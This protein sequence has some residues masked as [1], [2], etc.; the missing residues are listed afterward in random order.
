M[1]THPELNGLRTWIEVDKTALAHNY[2][3]LRGILPT[4]T[5]FMA[6]VK[7]N[8]YGHSLV[9]FSQEVEKLGADWIAV[10]SIVE[11]ETLREQGIKAPILVLGFTLPSKIESAADLGVSLSISSFEMLEEVAEFAKKNPAKKL[12]L[13]IKVDTGM[14]RQGFEEEQISEV[15]SHLKKLPPNVLVEGLFTHFASAKNP[16][17]PNHT[18]GQISK[19]ELWRA[20]FADAGLKPLCHAGASS[21]SILYP[22]SH[23]DMVRFG[24]TMYGLWP[25]AQVR[26]YAEDKLDLQPIL[27]WKTVIAEVK[28]VKKGESVGYDSTEILKRDSLLAV[29]PIGYWH[30]L[31]RA[32]SGIGSVIVAGKR[33]K[34]IGRVSMD[35]I[36]IDVTDIPDAEFG[37]QV[38]V[39]GRD[40]EEEI[41]AGEIATLSETSDYEIVTRLNPL[42]KRIFV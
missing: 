37:S 14:H 8:A 24:I 35:M 11:A 40:G 41:S 5:K 4:K 2:K 18:L 29:C 6:V 23:F 17:F 15:V 36:T 42:I 26:A 33:A 39:L 21:G 34:I 27:T 30:G 9:D 1:K 28:K 16:A 31:P 22:Q 25:S 3:I 10:D 38:T 32:V 20:A 19:F 13:H 7:S 12:N